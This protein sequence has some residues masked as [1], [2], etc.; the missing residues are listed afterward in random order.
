MPEQL[1]AIV[2]F[3]DPQWV[4]PLLAVL[5]SAWFIRSRWKRAERVEQ[6]AREMGI[7]FSTGA[8]ELLGFL[9]KDQGE[10]AQNESRSGLARFLG[11]FASWR[12]DGRVDGVPVSVYQF[13]ERQTSSSETEQKYTLLSAHRLTHHSTSACRC[14]DGGPSRIVEVLEKVATNL[15]PTLRDRTEVSSVNPALDEKL[16]IQMRS[17]Q[18]A[19][20]L[21]ADAAVQDQV[22]RAMELEG[23]VTIDD[24]GARLTTG[25]GFKNPEKLRPLL[26]VLCATASLLKARS[27]LRDLKQGLLGASA[28]LA[29]S[30]CAAGM[31]A[32]RDHPRT[33]GAERRQPARPHGGAA[34]RNTESDLP[35]ES[36]LADRQEP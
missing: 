3:L 24:Q 31:I 36:G 18:A 7:R 5:A 27:R 14:C 6:L 16:V 32:Q 21:F 17:P 8:D 1:E 9:R 12:L 19:R 33:S 2:H 11:L 4:F 13:K 15:L 34:R 29:P 30:F 10:A 20:K 22:L 23:Q 28:E 26:I 35:P 25:W